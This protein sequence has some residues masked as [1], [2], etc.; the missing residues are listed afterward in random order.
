MTLLSVVNRS[1]ISQP[2][3]ATAEPFLGSDHE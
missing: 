3:H 1:G 2:G